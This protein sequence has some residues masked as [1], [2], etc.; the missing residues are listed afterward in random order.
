MRVTERC[1]ARL[2]QLLGPHRRDEGMTVMEVV[3]A[4]TIEDGLSLFDREALDVLGWDL[5]GL[6]A[7]VDVGGLDGEGEANLLEELAAARRG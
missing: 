5:V 1:A 6:E 7:L 4:M 3:V 2:R